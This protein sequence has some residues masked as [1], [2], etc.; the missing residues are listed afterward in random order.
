MLVL[1]WLQHAKNGLFERILLSFFPSFEAMLGF[2]GRYALVSGLEPSHLSRHVSSIRGGFVHRV[3][4]RINKPLPTTVTMTEL[5]ENLA[6]YLDAAE[7]GETITITRRG[8]PSVKLVTAA[9]E[10]GALDLAA[11]RASLGVRVGA[12]AV[13]R[14]RQGERD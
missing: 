5:R 7:A 1:C 4:L 14:L 13:S 6:S 2:R 8:K 9:Q 3:Q 12:G 11:F 10:Q